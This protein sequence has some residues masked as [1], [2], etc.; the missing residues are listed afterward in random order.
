MKK[1]A[2]LIALIFSFSSPA[3]AF[4]G[5]AVLSLDPASGTVN[6]GCTV[7]VN[8]RVDTGGAETDGT[9]AIITYD[10]AIF[11]LTSSNITNGTI[12][13]DYPGNSVDPSG[14]IA[15]SGLASVSQAFTTASGQ[16]GVLATINFTVKSDA[17]LRATSVAFDFDTNNKT[18]TTDSNVVERGTVADVLNSVNNATFTVGSGACGTQT[19]TS[20]GGTTVTTTGT[21]TAVGGTTVI[22]VKQAY[23][24]PA[25]LLKT[26]DSTGTFILVVAGSVLTVLGIVGLAVL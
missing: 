2:A 21:K 16:S 15:I 1:L 24:S 26:G 17:P 19:A 20:T 6:R 10:P 12:Y 5:N 9:D 13:S 14:K 23:S 3:L 22:P 8:V 25:A 7:S 18:K 4:A 11:S